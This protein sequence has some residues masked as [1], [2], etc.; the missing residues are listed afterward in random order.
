MLL[1]VDIGNS[2][3]DLGVF[4][5]LGKLQMKSKMSTV[6]KKC[7][8]EYAVI[9]NGIFSLHQIDMHSI[10]DCIVSSVV[11]SLTASVAAAVKKLTACSVMEVGTGMKTGLNIKVDSQTQLG[12]DLVANAVGAMSQYKPPLLIIDIGTATT[13]TVL[14][15]SGTFEGAIICPGVRVSL[16]ALTAYTAALPDVPITPPRH[17]IGKNS[18]D[19]MNSGVLFGHAFMIDGFID[20]ITEE[21][22]AKTLCVIVTGGLCDVVLPY[23][24]HKLI[25]EPELTLRGLFQ[26]FLKNRK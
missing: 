2:S 19:S 15:E 25:R 4:D 14:G 12:A 16:D 8:D 5:G 18:G 21:L 13:F 7:T 11:P 17:F 10:T 24:K 23:C 9:L 20:R 3:I 6:R 22:G 26:L 1:A